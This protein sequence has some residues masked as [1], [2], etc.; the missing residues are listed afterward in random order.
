MAR[1][2]KIKLGKDAVSDNGKAVQPD[3]GNGSQLAN[4]T[5]SNQE[6]TQTMVQETEQAFA[7]AGNTDDQDGNN[8][9]LAE[10]AVS[11][12]NTTTNANNGGSEE[13]PDEELKVRQNMTPED[14]RKAYEKDIRKFGRNQALG[15]LAKIGMAEKLLEG[16]VNDVFRIA[17]FPGG[18]SINDA[19]DMYHLF[20]SQRKDFTDLD[21]KSGSF[22]QNVKKYEAVINLGQQH[23]DEALG[24][25]GKV[26]DIFKK[27]V[28]QPDLRK[29]IK[30]ADAGI[31]EAVV[32]VIREQLSRDSAAN[33]SEPLLD[34]AEILEAMKSH[35]VSKVV[36]AAMKLVEAVK[37][38]NAAN[39]G[40]ETKSG[41]GNFKG[42]NHDRLKSIIEELND[43][44]TH[45]L[46]P[47]DITTYR[48]GTKPPKKT[49]RNTKPITSATSPDQSPS[50]SHPNGGN[51][52]NG[53]G[54]PT[55]T[56]GASG[57]G[58]AETNSGDTS[59]D[60]EEQEEAQAQADME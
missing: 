12:T 34:D 29:D 31:F 58:D 47:N 30:L 44:A 18:K 25:F 55:S 2:A 23:R 59:V 60:I 8:T 51:G 3:N 28:A 19:H 48:N 17:E 37:A 46:N 33:A 11:T 9:S 53:S 35:N 32:D 20:A 14:L 15:A 13:E 1:G 42:L 50:A 54:V 41:K 21:L 57:T 38:L 36:D 7:G 10:G 24:W 49:R 43:F 27:A 26:C 52:G 22:S 16:T 6:D 45:D 4:E 56:H 39:D 40:V 5:P